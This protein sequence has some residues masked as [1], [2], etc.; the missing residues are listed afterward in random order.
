MVGAILGGDDGTDDVVGG[1]VGVAVLQD[2][3]HTE[4][5]NLLFFLLQRFLG[6]ST[7]HEQSLGLPLYRNVEM[8]SVHSIE[9]LGFKVEG[10]L[11]GTALGT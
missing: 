8:L 2:I 5:H 7:T 3:L 9:L 6:F 10:L 4:G 1:S 11:V